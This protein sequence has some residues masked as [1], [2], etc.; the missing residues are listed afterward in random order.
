MAGGI[1]KILLF[2][3]MANLVA[4]PCSAGSLEKGSGLREKIGQMLMVGFRGLDV[5]EDSWVVEDIRKGRIGGVILYDYD[6]ARNSSRRNIES[7]RQ[8]KALTSEL[9]T[10]SKRPLLIAV[11]QEGG[12]VARLK[13]KNGFP[14]TVSQAWLGRQN[15]PDLTGTYASKT[16]KTLARMGI[17]IN[18]APVVDV[19]LNPENPVIGR[20]ERS[21]SSDPE[22]VARH[23]KEVIASHREKGVLTALKHFPGH[24]SSSRDTH[25]GFTDVTHT[26]SPKELDP[27]REIFATVGAD[28]VMT[29]HVFNSRLDPEWP[30]SL[31]SRILGD[32]L[33][34][35][36]DY[37]GVIISDDMQMGAIRKEYSLET[38]L[39][40]TILA[41]TDIIVFGNNLVYEPG[42]AQKAIT[43]ITDLVHKGCIP[44]WRIN[45]SYER[46]SQLKNK[47][48]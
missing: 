4:F 22:L 7:P 9:Q 23:A 47:L 14:S 29:A 44:A 3:L 18:L 21:F 5:D 10:A 1:Q 31:S 12:Q 46:I 6:V 26:W 35:K 33:R 25:Q 28:M 27:Y 16:A 30:A 32:L 20:L 41:G 45:T 42:I 34:G 17:N 37:Q 19:N 15:D 13:E 11:D 48:D 8:L 2:A 36:M 38:A 40:R 24:G 39:E 43:I